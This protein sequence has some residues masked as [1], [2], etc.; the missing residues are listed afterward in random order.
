MENGRTTLAIEFDPCASWFIVFKDPVRT[1]A[2]T[3]DWTEYSTVS[4]L[5]GPWELAFDPEWGGPEKTIFNQLS[6]WSTHK[7]EGIRYYS[8]K[9][10]Y[11]KTF[12]LPENFRGQ[13]HLP[14]SG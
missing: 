6:D 1:R 7:D 8:G 4:E 5:E 12:D 2:Q 14:G 13:S 9:A 11:T 10:T 3:S